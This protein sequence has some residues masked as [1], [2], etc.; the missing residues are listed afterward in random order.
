M[1]YDSDLEGKR[2]S[3]GLH[4]MPP[5]RCEN[6]QANCGWAYSR[7]RPAFYQSMWHHSPLSHHRC[8]ICCLYYGRETSRKSRNRCTLLFMICWKALFAYR[9]NSYGTPYESLLS[10]CAYFAFVW[11]ESVSTGRHFGGLSYL[12]RCSPRICSFPAL[13]IAVLNVI[14]WS[15]LNIIRWTLL[16]ADEAMLGKEY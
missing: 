5:A 1:F 14:L 12:R 4:K 16:H 6:L 15:L 3:Q 11:G 13:F 10:G 9:V 8:H 2:Q 7:Y